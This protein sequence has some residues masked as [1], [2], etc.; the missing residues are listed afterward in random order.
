MRVP[1][2]TFQTINQTE[3]LSPNTKTISKEKFAPHL[4]RPN[5]S[6]KMASTAAAD[7][8]LEV[9]ELAKEFK[10]GTLTKE[11]ASKRFASLVMAKRHNL[12]SLGPKGKQ[13]HDAVMEIAGDD[14]HF[15]S[16]LSLQLQKLS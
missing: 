8:I 3:S 7:L 16:A 15:I 10:S 14:P 5:E 1:P 6:G 9:Q 11:D 2:S 12:D 13:V 4:S